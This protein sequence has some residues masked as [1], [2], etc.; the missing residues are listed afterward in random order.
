M[1]FFCAHRPASF[2]GRNKHFLSTLRRLSR[3]GSLLLLLIVAPAG[4]VAM[5]GIRYSSVGQPVETHATRLTMPSFVLMGGDANVDEA[6]RWMISKAGGGNFLVIGVDNSDEYN[7]YIYRM[8]GVSSVQTLIIPDAAAARNP[9]VAARIREADALFI[10]GGDQSEYLRYWQGT[11]VQEA[12]QDL[13]R[14]NVPIGGISAGLAI[15]GQY[16]FSAARGSI[17]SAMALADPY[18]ERLTLTR[19]F[20][21][22][23]HFE[24]IIMDTHFDTRNRL[25]RLIAFMARITKD[26]EQRPVRGIGVDSGAALLI[27][28]DTAMRVGKA[29]SAVYL[30]SA[31]NPP[32]VCE[33]GQ[34]LTY[35]DI[36]VHRLTGDER[37]DMRTWTKNETRKGI[38]LASVAD[39]KLL[40][41]AFAPAPGELFHWEY[42]TY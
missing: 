14:R 26:T 7:E 5:H 40:K 4:H 36:T 20:L 2:P 19:D 29:A 24:G 3:M 17:G 8:G 37:F 35:R 6:F 21:D 9:K 33:P 25:G 23:P 39:G 38:Y 18:H 13:A 1:L 31:H 10:M 27:E 41:S 22:L 42:G 11:P 16:V 30:L 12:I 34:P 15:L 32:D 28:G